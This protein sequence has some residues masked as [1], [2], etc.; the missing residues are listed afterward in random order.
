MG[1]REKQKQK[2][3]RR[4]RGRSSFSY[5][6]ED[7][8]F[9]DTPRLSP[10]GE[11]PVDDSNAEEEEDDADEATISH[12]N[13]SHDM[14]SKFLL[15]QQSVQVCVPILKKLDLCQWAYAW[16]SWLLGWMMKCARFKIVSFCVFLGEFTS[17]QIYGLLCDFFVLIEKLIM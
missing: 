10:S 17:S 1:K 15:Y 9:D 12:E 2:H 14:P 16:F 3:E 6:Q 4:N 8:D 5:L 13:Q 11:E 7:Q